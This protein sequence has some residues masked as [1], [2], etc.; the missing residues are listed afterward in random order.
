[1]NPN[2]R[3]HWVQILYPLFAYYVL[4]YISDSIALSYVGEERGTLALFF[5]SLVTLGP[6]YLF[7]KRAPILRLS[8][9]ATRRDWLLEGGYILGI[10]CLGLKI[11]LMVAGLDLLEYSSSYGKSAYI[12]HTGGMFLRILVLGILIPL[13]EELLFRGV[14]LGQLL[15]FCDIKWGIIISSVLFG[16]LHFNVVQFLY[17]AVMGSLLGL[18]Y[19]KT[20]HVWATWI[21]HGLC[22]LLVLFIIG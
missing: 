18:L 9:P 4:Y 12:L 8:Y 11:N 5:A 1:M 10:A 7:Y 2:R 20:R 19:A 17:A 15:N 21:A 16:I 14:I 6:V 3:N 22:N 13:L